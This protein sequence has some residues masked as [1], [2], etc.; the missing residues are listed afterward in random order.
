MRTPIRHLFMK[1]LKHTATKILISFVLLS[2]LVLQADWQLFITTLLQVHSHYLIIAMLLFFTATLFSVLRWSHIFMI[3]NMR[4]PIS[5]LYVLYVLGSF[6]NNF[7]PTSVGGDVYKYIRLNKRYVGRRGEILASLLGERG[8][9]FIAFVILNL[10]LSMSYLHMVYASKPLMLLEIFIALTAPAMILLYIAFT[11]NTRPITLLHLPAWVQDKITIA[12]DLLRAMRLR[13]RRL[14]LAFLYS[15][16]FAWN[17]AL[18]TWFIFLAFDLNISLMYTLFIITIVN[19]TGVL[20]ISFNSI[21]ISEGLQVF[22]LS[23]IGVPF[24]TALVAATIARLAHLFITAASG[25]PL[26]ILYK[27]TNL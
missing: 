5:Y 20:P 24:E 22:L 2:V 13:P 4:P 3:F 12:R 17:I 15:V 27:Q 9:G 8:I 11:Y 21:G 19:I 18:S 26:Y 10:L 14:F 1:I 16:L 25:I 7:L 23:L 6:L